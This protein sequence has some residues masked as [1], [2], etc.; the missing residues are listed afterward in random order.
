MIIAGDH[1]QMLPI[2]EYFLQMLP[3]AEARTEQYFQHGGIFFSET[4][5]IFGAFGI[6]DYVFAALTLY[7]LSFNSVH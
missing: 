3:F 5:T 1:E 7:S 2:F 4:K 6:D